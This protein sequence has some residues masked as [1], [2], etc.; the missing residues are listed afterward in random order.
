MLSHQYFL[1]FSYPT[2]KF[3][4]RTSLDQ[5]LRHIPSKVE[6]S[7][8]VQPT[9][10]PSIQCLEHIVTR[11]S[12]DSHDFTSGVDR[13]LRMLDSERTEVNTSCLWVGDTLEYEKDISRT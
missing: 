9:S 8:V 6:F 4:T 11:Y 1:K 10:F 7:Y 12:I 3:V 5:A 13:A 2:H